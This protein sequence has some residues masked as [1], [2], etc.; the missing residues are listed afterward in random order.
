MDGVYYDGAGNMLAIVDEDPKPGDINDDGKGLGIDGKEREEMYTINDLF[1]W[2][3]GHDDVRLVFE[4][5]ADYDQVIHI[6]MLLRHHSVAQAISLINDEGNSHKDLP[7]ILNEAYQNLMGIRYDRLDSYLD[8]D[9][10]EIRNAVHEIE[11]DGDV[12]WD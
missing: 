9:V 10:E 7:E 4:K 8:S 6:T 1:Q 5:S 2:L 3:K 11:Q 12:T